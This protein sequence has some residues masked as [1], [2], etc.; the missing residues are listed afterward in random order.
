MP[1]PQGA[2]LKND[3]LQKD[4]ETEGASNGQKAKW[5]YWV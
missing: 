4:V 5:K 3:Q 2:G 1:R